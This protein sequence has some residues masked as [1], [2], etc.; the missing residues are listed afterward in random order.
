M[1]T[2]SKTNVGSKEKWTEEA[3]KSAVE[4]VG[5]GGDEDTILSIR[6]A[7][8]RFNV[9]VETRRRRVTRLVDVN[10]RHGPHPVFS[11]C[12]TTPVGFVATVTPVSLTLYIN[13]GLAMM[14]KSCVFH[15]CC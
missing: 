6:G 11:I 10:C 12:V 9:P 1:A 4:A 3:M 7:T 15:C 13:I 14:M 8:K 5:D 2:S